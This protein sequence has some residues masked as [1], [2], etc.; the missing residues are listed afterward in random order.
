MATDLRGSNALITGASSGIGREIA[1]ELARRGARLAVVARSGERLRDLADELADR[2]F[3]RP[4]PI[5]ADLSTRGAAAEAA[6]AAIAELGHVDVL[7][8]NA[9]G[10]VH[11]WETVLGDGPEAREVFELNVWAPQALIAALAPAMRDRR[12]GTVVNVTSMMQIMPWPT[13]GIYAASKA[14]LG[15]LTGTLRL[16]LAPFAV[17]VIEVI[18][19]AVATAMQADSSLI[20]GLHRAN[21]RMAVGDPAV[22]ARAVAVAIES[23]AP[24]VVYPASLRAGYALPFAVR[25][26]ATRWATKVRADFDFEDNRTLLS[27]GPESRAARAAWER[28][29]RDPERL[30]A[31]TLIPVPESRPASVSRTRRKPLRPT[32]DV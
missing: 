3:V 19:G 13:T 1:V 2:G 25:R 16:E 4:H 24:R 5:V 30:R 32:R 28:G 14:A 23:G 9:G 11:G 7:V 6:G 26:L 29:E 10:G 22:L 20:P 27:G 8:N 21:R 12:R 15:A 18:P 17:D 31:A